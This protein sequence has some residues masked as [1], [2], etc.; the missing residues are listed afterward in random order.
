MEEN[1]FGPRFGLDFDQMHG[2]WVTSTH[3]KGSYGRIAFREDQTHFWV[4]WTNNGHGNAKLK[5]SASL[6]DVEHLKLLPVEPEPWFGKCMH[7]GSYALPLGFV[8][9]QKK[10]VS[11]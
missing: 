5:K 1:G 3:F 9:L 2:V 6:V 7:C 10:S 11:I 4:R 8:D